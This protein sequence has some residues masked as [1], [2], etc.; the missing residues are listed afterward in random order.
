MLAEDKDKI[1]NELRTV[2]TDARKVETT[3]QCQVLFLD[4][5]K[6]YFHIALCMSPVGDTLRVRCRKFPSL[7]NCCT[8][9]NFSRWPADALLYVS[10]AFLKNLELPSDEVRENIAQMC[11]KIHTSVEEASDRFWEELRRRI[12]TTPKSYLD[13]ISLYINVLA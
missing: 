1:N 9:D 5:V 2:I 11:M 13:L 6:E 4:R 10:R 8:L 3:D 7:V 12:Y